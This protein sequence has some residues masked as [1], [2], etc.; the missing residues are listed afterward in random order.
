MSEFERS[1]ITHRAA[2]SVLGTTPA[3]AVV[4]VTTS[5]AAADG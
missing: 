2:L 3:G 1:P 4:A 5:A